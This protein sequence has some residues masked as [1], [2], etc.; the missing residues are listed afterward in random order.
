[1]HNSEDQPGKIG[2]E[3]PFTAE[4][5]ALVFEKPAKSES[6]NVKVLRYYFICCEHLSMRR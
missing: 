6:S 2:V 4:I 3:G 1:M 5:E